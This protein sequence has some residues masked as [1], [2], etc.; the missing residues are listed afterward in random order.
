M[1]VPDTTTF[2]MSDVVNELQL[3][4]CS[5][6]SLSQLF[7]CAPNVSFDSSYE[8]SQICLLNYRNYN[9][10]TGW[11]ITAGAI[12]MGVTYDGTNVWTANYARNSVSKISPTSVETEYSGTCAQPL[13]IIYDGTNLWT[14]NHSSCSVSRITTSG[15]I[16]NVV[17]GANRC[18]NGLTHAPIPGCNIIWV[19]TQSAPGFSSIGRYLHISATTAACVGGTTAGYSCPADIVYDDGYESRALT[20]AHYSDVCQ[21]IQDILSYYLPGGTFYASRTLGVDAFPRKVAWDGVESAWIGSTCGVTKMDVFDS[22]AI[23]NYYTLPAS[24]GVAADG[25]HVWTSDGTD[26]IKLNCNGTIC[27]TFTNITPGVGW[28]VT[29]ACDYIFI[30]NCTTN[31]VI[32]MG[33]K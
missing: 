13:A 23:S 28:T 4:G 20:V 16:T 29:Y 14:A 17:L 5:T 18:A 1:A 27:N 11:T 12:P 10:I 21:P 6:M 22:C 15:T 7:T 24:T 8:G 3:D 30:G 26:I 31:C 25:T 32:R 2:R 19:A 33:V 9:L